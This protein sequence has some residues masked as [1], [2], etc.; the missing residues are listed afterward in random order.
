MAIE[1]DDGDLRRD[2]WI[3]WGVLAASSAV[4]G[5]FMKNGDGA[6]VGTVRV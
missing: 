5:T 4:R 6:S 2:L 1:N 3:Q